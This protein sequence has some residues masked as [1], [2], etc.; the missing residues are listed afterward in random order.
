MTIN[1]RGSRKVPLQSLLLVEFPLSSSSFSCAY[2]SQRSGFSHVYSYSAPGFLDFLP[3]KRGNY[4]HFAMTNIL[5]LEDVREMVLAFPTLEYYLFGLTDPGRSVVD[6]IDR[7]TLCIHLEHFTRGLR[8]PLPCLPVQLLNTHDLLLAQLTPNEI[9]YILAFIILCRDKAVDTTTFFIGHSF[10]PCGGSRKDWVLNF[11][12]KERVQAHSR[13]ARNPDHLD[14]EIY[15][16]TKLG[17]ASRAF[18]SISVC[19]PSGSKE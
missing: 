16:S 18:H 2:C 11:G 10:L 15:C 4:F 9:S 1:Y 13:P 3:P 17:L 14:E 8:L 12:T 7:E 6:Y 5:T 19:N